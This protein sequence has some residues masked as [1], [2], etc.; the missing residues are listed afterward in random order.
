MN[1][2]HN[3]PFIISLPEP[4]DAFIRVEIHPDNEYRVGGQVR[5]TCVTSGDK[6][7]LF[8]VWSAAGNGGLILPYGIG[9]SVFPN[10]VPILQIIIYAGWEVRSE[11]PVSPVVT[12]PHSFL[13]GLLPVTVDSYSRTGSVSQCVLPIL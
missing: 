5:A 7:P 10:C 1:S 8:P 6:A 3:V 2:F 11:L 9:E 12:R 13:F 4:K